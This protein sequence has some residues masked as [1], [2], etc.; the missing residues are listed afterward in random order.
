MVFGMKIGPKKIEIVLGD[1][2]KEKFGLDN[3]QW[4]DLT[5]NIDVII[6]NGAFVHWVYPY[7]QLRDANVIGTINVL[8]MAGEGKAKF[9]SFVSSTSALDTDYFVNLSDELLAQGKNGISEADDL[10]GSA[11]GLGNGY[12]QSKWAAEYIIRRA[13]ERGLKGCIT[14][15]GYV[16]GFSK[17]GASILMIS[18]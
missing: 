11:K 3:S 1:L 8:N 5:N 14:R 13:G 10:Q 2:S 17:T 6:H 4:S 12:G 7:S 15:P 18:Y 9:F 16:T